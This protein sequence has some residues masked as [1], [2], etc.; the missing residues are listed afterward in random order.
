MDPLSAKTTIHF[1]S[2]IDFHKS[3]SAKTTLYFMSQIDF[4][5]SENVLMSRFKRK[6]GT[7]H[8]LLLKYLLRHIPEATYKCLY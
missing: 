3:I 8:K 1:T 7:R 4:H 5:E 6:L 2:Q